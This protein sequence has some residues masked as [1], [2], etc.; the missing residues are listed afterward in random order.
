MSTQTPLTWSGSGPLLRI[1]MAPASQGPLF[2]KNL[3]TTLG[4][5]CQVVREG[6]R[7][8]LHG[9]GVGDIDLA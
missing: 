5:V 1:L 2:P 8:T 3:P 4:L 9:I 6:E 7:R